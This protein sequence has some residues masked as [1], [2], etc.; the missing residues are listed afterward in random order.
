MQDPGGQVQELAER[1][2]AASKIVA[3]TGAGISTAAGIPDFRG[4]QGIYFTRRYPEDVFDIQAFD[5]DPRGFYQ[6]ARDFLEQRRRISPSFAHGVLARL[7]G[8]GRL[9]GIVTQNID[10]L[11]QR[12]GSRLVIEVHGGFGHAHC[13]GC[14]RGFLIE[15]LEDRVLAGEV[16]LCEGCGAVIKP[17]IVFFGENVRDFERAQ[18]LVAASDLLLVIGTSLTVYPAASLPDSAPGETVIVAQGV[19]P[20]LRRRARVIESEI[21][22]F[23]EA[24][25]ARLWA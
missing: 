18:A 11:H 10:G 14:A 21:E 25:S 12:A 8:E 16:P 5:R 3:L 24:L 1:I 13:R 23:F 20:A 6:F 22:G 15:E 2:R 17:D 4:P 9:V 7:E 19:A